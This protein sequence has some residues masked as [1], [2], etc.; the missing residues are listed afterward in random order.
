M[1]AIARTVIKVKPGQWNAITEFARSQTQK[2]S[3]VAGLLHWGWAESAENEFTAIVVYKD[4]EAAEKAAPI[5]AEIFAEAAPMI[6]APPLREILNAE[7][8][9]P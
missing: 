9:T 8:F 2:V 6:A 7:W 1:A 4:R 3:S 5:A